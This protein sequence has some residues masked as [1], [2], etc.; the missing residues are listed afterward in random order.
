MQRA[1]RT[2]FS[3][4]AVALAALALVSC[5]RKSEGESPPAPNPDA[6]VLVE[7]E[8]HFQGDVTIYLVR[9]GLRQRLGLVTALNTQT[10]TFPWRWVVSGGNNRLMAYPIAGAESYFSDP[11][12]LQSGQWLKWTLMADL[13]RSSLAVYAGSD[14]Q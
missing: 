6:P 10:F 7:V 5:G 1:L 14:E 8:S 4:A 11:F 13:G 12:D 2:A 3:H 9:G